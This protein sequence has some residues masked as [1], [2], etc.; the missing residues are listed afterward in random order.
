MIYPFYSTKQKS[1]ELKGRF[2]IGLK[3]L[4]QLG[5]NLTVHSAPFHF[6]SR[7]DHVAMVEEAAPIDDFYDPHAN[8]TMVSVD[9]YPDYDLDSLAAWFDVW[10][11]SDLIFLDNVRAIT[12]LDL[13]KRV[14]LKHL[15]IQQTQP[16]CHFNLALAKHQSRVTHS[17]FLVDNALWERFVCEVKVPAGKARAAKATGH[18]TPIGIAMPVEGNARGRLHVALPTKIHT[19]AAFSLDAQFD[20]STSREDMIHGGWNQW[21]TEASGQFLGE[22]AIQLMDV[23]AAK[24]AEEALHRSQIELAHIT[25]IT[26][27]GELAASIAHEVN[28]PLAAVTTNGSAG[29]RWLNRDV[30]DIGEVRNSIELMM[31]ETHRA[32]EVIRRIRAMSRK[33]DPQNTRL[34]L[35]E[36]IEESL[37]LVEREVK[38]NKIMLAHDFDCGLASITGDRVQLQQVIINLIMNGMQSMV[39]TKSKNRTLH[40]GLCHTETGDVVVD[41][42]DSGPGISAENMPKLFNAFFTTKPDGMGMGLSICR[43]IIEA[44]G[45]RI[46]ATNHPGV[47]AALHFSLPANLEACE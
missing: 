22:L 2:G 15:A 46:W 35:K 31:S 40:L 26:T 21:L 41:V 14:S 11:P 24:I 3:T 8:Q 30:P 47:G 23:T 1:A 44:H 27:L 28:Q 13:D 7:D 18:Y 25:R 37:A 29:L 5:E 32:S 33:T 6:G 38:R 20:P 4:T 12:L 17:T 9:L 16:T 45:G 39:T 43:S 10:A 36:V 19:N 34:D 42:Q